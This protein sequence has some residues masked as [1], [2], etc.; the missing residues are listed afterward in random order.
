MSVAAPG[1]PRQETNRLVSWARTHPLL[2]DGVLSIALMA[3]TL[4]SD[5]AVDPAGSER[6]S[7]LLGVALIIVA[8][9]VVVLR[10]R[11]PQLTLLVAL[12]TTVPYWILDYPGDAAGLSLLVALYSNAAYTPRRERAMLWAAASMA[13]VILVVSF[14]VL[15]PEEEL[16]VTEMFG[17]IVQFAIAAV[18]GDN[19][20]N[21]RAYVAE[22]EARVIE[23]DHERRAAEA[24]AVAEERTR[25]ARELHDVVAH[26]MNV[27]VL[28][29]QVG[30][31]ML[32]RD[33]DR[34]REAL[35]SIEDTGRESLADMRRILGILRNGDEAP[36][37]PQP[38]LD[39]FAALVR[40]C[41]DAGIPVE[42]V[43]EG[44]VRVL[45]AGT[46]LAA[47]RI[48]QEALTN[49]VKHAGQARA[50]VTISYGDTDLDIAVSDDGRGAAADH[51]DKNGSGLGLVGMRERVELYGGSFDAGPQPGGGYRVH[52]RLPLERA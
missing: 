44:D 46:E 27:M 13:V 18:L 11:Y 12:V 51:S 31:R 30:N 1:L 15:S 4:A 5:L 32:E 49:T 34:A 26:S 37:A 48:V 35:G 14:G 16:S 6:D 50:T 33:T 29:A 20:R 19:I 41:E 24:R 8:N 43:V 23:G 25:I 47:F 36:L 21:R 40:H 45:P 22:I 3:V 17:V 9:A 42:L 7:E 52:A 10:R 38:K 2:V 28:H 39:E